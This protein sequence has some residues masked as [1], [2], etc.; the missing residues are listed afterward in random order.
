MGIYYTAIF[1]SWS[2]YIF[3]DFILFYFIVIFYAHKNGIC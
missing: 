3:I 1:L 2:F